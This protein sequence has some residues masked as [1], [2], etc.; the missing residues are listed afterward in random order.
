M[1]GRSTQCRAFFRAQN[2]AEHIRR[3]FALAGVSE[4]VMTND[5]LDPDEAPLWESGTLP[6]A[7]FRAALR[8]DRILND[9]S[10]DGGGRAA[11]ARNV[12]EADGARVH[13]GLAAGLVHVPRR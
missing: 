13:G 2:L 11:T 12:V 1:R 8:L 6:D 7:G 4:V 5:P 3:V 10:L 9:R